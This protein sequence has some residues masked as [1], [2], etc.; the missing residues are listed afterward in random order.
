MQGVHEGSAEANHDRLGE[1]IAPPRQHESSLHTNDGMAILV[2][3]Y[4]I[5]FAKTMPLLSKDQHKV[6]FCC[7]LVHTKA[8]AKVALHLELRRPRRHRSNR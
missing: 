5:C 7:R 8:R 6:L 1:P 3:Q 2:R 4:H